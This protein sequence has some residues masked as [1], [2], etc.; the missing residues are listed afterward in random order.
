MNRAARAGL[1]A[2]VSGAVA[3][4][5][6]CTTVMEAGMLAE[7]QRY[8]AAAEET[9]SARS[10]APRD[11][12]HGRAARWNISDAA[13]N[14]RIAARNGTVIHWL[15]AVRIPGATLA[16]LRDVLRDYP[17]YDRIYRPMVF[18][19]RKVEEEAGEDRLVLG[20]HSTFR[21]AAL[22]P[23]QYSFEARGTMQDPELSG[24]GTE[25]RAHLRAE[26]IRESD[27]GT[28][29]RTD[30]LEPYRDHGIMW[31]LNAYWRAKQQSEAVYL[32]FETITLARS[33][34]GFSCSIGFIPVPKAV[35]SSAMESLPADSVMV[36][37]EGT[38]AECQRRASGR[39]GGLPRR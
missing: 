16:E 12:A 7:Y 38:K 39:R 33:V 29:G 3:W 31:A 6:R 9:M 11:S 26:E 13:F 19:C 17:H 35:V 37:L 21:F 28:P 25:L 4:A 15:G 18:A 20:L 2:V 36:V 32:E 10:A 30:W 1:L 27:S 5:A 23:Q 14:R 34:E 22:F 8:V 24:D